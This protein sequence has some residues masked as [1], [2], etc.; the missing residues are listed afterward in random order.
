MKTDEDYMQKALEEAGRA[1]ALEEVPIGAVIVYENEII[2]GG[3]NLKES[4]Q[5]PTAHAE[6][7]AIRKAAEKLNSWRLPECDLYVT[8][9]PCPMCAGA[10]LQAR[11]PRLI[12]GADDIKAGAAGSLYNL[13]QDERFNHQIEVRGGVLAEKSRSLLQD[14]FRKLRE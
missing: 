4:L 10:M 1:L 6:M 3:H 11:M 13:V 5:D 14:F 8:V 2:A 9:E 7:I 12:Y